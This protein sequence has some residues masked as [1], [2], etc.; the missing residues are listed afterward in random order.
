MSQKRAIEDGQGGPS[1]KTSRP[2]VAATCLAVS[3]PAETTWRTDGSPYIGRRILCAVG[4]RKS[5]TWAVVTAWLPAHLSNFTNCHGNKAALWRVVYEDDAVGEE[6]FEED[7]LK[8]AMKSAD[9]KKASC[10]GS[11]QSIAAASIG[12]AGGCAAP[13]LGV[14]NPANEGWMEGRVKMKNDAAKAANTFEKVTVEKEL[15]RCYCQAWDIDKSVWHQND[16]K[17][18]WVELTE[19]FNKIELGP[20]MGMVICPFI[21][22]AGKTFTMGSCMMHGAAPTE[23]TIRDYDGCGVIDVPVGTSLTWQ[24]DHVVQYSCGDVKVCFIVVKIPGTPPPTIWHPDRKAKPEVQTSA[25]VEKLV[26]AKFFIM[27][28]RALTMPCWFT[29]SMVE[30]E[31]DMWH[32][33]VFDMK[34]G[35]N[36]LFNKYKDLMGD[37]TTLRQKYKDEMEQNISLIDEMRLKSTEL[38]DMKCAFDK[39]KRKRETLLKKYKDLAGKHT[40]LHEEL[41]NEMEHN[42]SLIDET[43]LKTTALNDIKESMMCSICLDSGFDVEPAVVSSCGHVLHEKCYWA[44]RPSMGNTC[45]KCMK[46]K[47]R[48]FQFTGYTGIGAA[49]QKLQTAKDA[50]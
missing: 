31:R 21:D 50:Q 39:M 29:A 4:L 35:C 15:Y 42:I 34:L 3:Q 7:E 30:N 40:K 16:E 26:R 20:N 2:T 32:S 38:H 10:G 17:N 19:D 6:D 49:F 18:A 9:Q 45:C 44:N 13:S 11:P 22:P 14:I 27:P 46:K 23:P 24:F 37:Y 33:A 28:H 12:G 43:R 25:D 48:W 47:A 8:Q 36:T 41:R 5:A 1:T